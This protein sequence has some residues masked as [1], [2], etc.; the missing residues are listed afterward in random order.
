MHFSAFYSCRN[1]DFS[2]FKTF[3]FW[4]RKWENLVRECC[5]WQSLTNLLKALPRG[6]SRKLPSKYNGSSNQNKV[7]I[8]FTLYRPTG[9]PT[10][11]F[12]FSKAC[13]SET[14]YLWPHYVG[15]AKKRLGCGYLFRFFSCLFTTF[16]INVR[17][18]NTFV[19]LTK[20][21]SKMHIFRV[22]YYWKVKNGSGTPCR[23]RRRVVSNDFRSRKRM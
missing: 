13:K 12:D 6:I 16:K 15:K 20:W 10:S 7:Q 11:I 5:L 3:W 8:W 23:R 4:V 19:A 17:L 2:C 22:I 9:C 14:M 1:G 18:S 21:G